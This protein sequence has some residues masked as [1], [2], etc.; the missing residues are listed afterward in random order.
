MSS[1]DQDTPTTT[2]KTDAYITRYAAAYCL[3][4][5]IVAFGV[6]YL[7]LNHRLHL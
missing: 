3:A 7:V 1:E 5:V 2:D 4:F 6:I